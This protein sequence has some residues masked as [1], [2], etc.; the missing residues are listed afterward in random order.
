VDDEVP[1]QERGI[2]EALPQNSE[3]SPTKYDTIS[4][5]EISFW[6]WLMGSSGLRIGLSYRRS[7]NSAA[8]TACG[9]LVHPI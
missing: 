4:A 9:E 7:T 2:A 5:A 1:E 8:F 6:P 3:A